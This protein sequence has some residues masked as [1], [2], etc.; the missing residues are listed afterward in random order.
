MPSLDL[1]IAEG[2]F[3]WSNPFWILN[4]WGGPNNTDSI[5][6]YTQLSSNRTG[7]D[8]RDAVPHTKGGTHQ[9]YV[10]DNDQDG[11]WEVNRRV[12]GSPID[13]FSV[14]YNNIFSPWSNP[15]S[16]RWNEIDTTD[17]TIEIL[18]TYTGFNGEDIYNLRI[19]MLN[20]EN[21]PP[22]RIP[23]LS[24]APDLNEHPLL[25]WA[26]NIEPD[27]EYYKVYKRKNSP[28]F[29]L[30][31]TSHTNDYTDLNEVFAN[32]WMPAIS[33]YYKVTAV[34]DQGKESN[35]SN[36]VAVPVNGRSS[37]KYSEW[38]DDKNMEKLIPDQ[39]EL[40][41]NY[42]NPFNPE[43]IIRFGLP[44]D[45]HISLRIYSILGQEITMLLDKFVAK[46]Y[47]EIVWDG[48]NRAGKEVSSAIYLYALRY[49]DQM[50]VRK[51]MLLR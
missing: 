2:R 41:Q 5:P 24:V 11:N 27:L 48:R 36:T 40:L 4:P 21:G 12:F 31:D 49:G 33:I 19:R 29:S 9:I 20:G 23:D 25:S 22:A 7:Y 16:N 6:V 43:T 18:G 1:E 3:N 44:R 51:M 38:S 30:Y 32:P 17:I 26:A 8:G 14:E 47:H 10:T 34:D 15:N 46:G 50:L 37:Q 45:Q 39:F 35:F 28:N 42:P 13:A